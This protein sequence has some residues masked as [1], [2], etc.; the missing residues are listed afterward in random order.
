[1]VV[2][3]RKPKW[4]E[5]PMMPAPPQPDV[6]D[7]TDLPKGEDGQPLGGDAKWT[8]YK[9]PHQ[10]CH[11]CIRALSQGVMA[12]HP[13]PARRKRAGVTSDPELLCHIHGERQETRDQM[14]KH[15]LAGVLASQKKRR[16]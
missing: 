9:G 7:P 10:P 13:Y 4:R 6:P 12:T 2:S 15:R 5:V 14:V 8:T 3:L 1:M 16:A 11:R